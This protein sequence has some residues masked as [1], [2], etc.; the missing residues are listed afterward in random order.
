[1]RPSRAPPKRSGI[2]ASQKYIAPSGLTNAMGM[3]RA[4]ITG[5]VNVS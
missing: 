5:T 3:D 2:S 4:K 1:M